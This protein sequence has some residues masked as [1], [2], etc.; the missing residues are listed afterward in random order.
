MAIF[1]NWRLMHIRIQEV[2]VDRPLS[3]PWYMTVGKKLVLLTCFLVHDLSLH[4][5]SLIGIKMS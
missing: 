3:Q 2:N 4:I 5:L 1:Q